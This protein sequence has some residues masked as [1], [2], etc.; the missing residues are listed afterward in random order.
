MLPKVTS[1]VEASVIAAPVP[2]PRLLKAPVKV[3]VPTAVPAAIV[4]SWF[5]PFRVLLKRIAPAFEFSVTAPDERVA[6]PVTV[7][8]SNPLQVKPS[9]V[10][11]PA[12]ELPVSPLVKVTL[13]LKRVAPP[14]LEETI[15]LPPPT[16]LPKVTSP[17][18]SSVIAAPVPSPRLLTAPVKVVV[19]AAVPAAI[20][21]S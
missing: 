19:P 6:A 17:V 21:R 12:K 3:V 15:P 7:S 8:P 11:V 2:S 16:V 9:S 20:L 14:A 10:T 18:E 5:P 13:S 4:R 1:P